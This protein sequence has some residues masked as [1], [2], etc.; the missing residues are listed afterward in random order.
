M[1]STGGEMNTAATSKRQAEL[2]AEAHA[3]LAARGGGGG[4]A[5]EQ[6]LSR[7]AT[8]AAQARA[9]ADAARLE[10]PSAQKLD[11]RKAPL[12]IAVC[13]GDSN[14]KEARTKAFEVL[15]AIRQGAGDRPIQV[16]HASD[17]R[18]G[19][20]TARWAAAH[21]FAYTQHTADWS[22]GGSAGVRRNER[23]LQQA[24][25]LV[26]CLPDG[27]ARARGHLSRTADDAM[28]MVIE[29]DGNEWPDQQEARECAEQAAADLAQ[30][31]SNLSPEQIRALHE[32]PGGI[33]ALV[34]PA[35]SEGGPDWP[36][37]RELGPEPEGCNRESEP[38]EVHVIVT[39]PRH[40]H[41]EYTV[42]EALKEI[43]ER[44]GGAPVKL[45]HG[46]EP[47]VE[48]TAT[49]W[50]DEQGIKTELYPA[51]WKTVN[52]QGTETN[53]ENAGVTRDHRMLDQ[54]RPDMVLVF[55]GTGGRTNQN[56][57][58]AAAAD[59]VPVEQVR[60]VTRHTADGLRVNLAAIAR[61]PY[62]AH[63]SAAER[64]AAVAAE[65]SE[66][67][68]SRPARSGP[69]PTD[70]SGMQQREALAAPVRAPIIR[71]PAMA[72]TGH[73]EVQQRG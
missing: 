57:V 47:G 29:A 71:A 61:T 46:G 18:Q 16:I 69:A 42:R 25:A 60:F 14:R 66:R 17:A 21:H 68:E 40:L 64:E 5:A 65:R 7:L 33:P 36:V 32:P 35:P 53:D 20:P 31:T 8:I 72:L 4:P 55:A 10:D 27:N 28:L 56:L 12:R 70:T 59:G 48:Q 41:S 9:A 11:R 23:V 3:R 19:T 6:R 62:P 39:G 45:I 67:D 26:A 22:S 30:R 52:A 63:L 13:G 49:E 37:A 24:P 15:E 54:G 51:E 50:A 2:L 1:N 73:R 58:R 34:G 43:V 44:A 38:R